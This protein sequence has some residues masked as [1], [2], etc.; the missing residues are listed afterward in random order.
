[1]NLEAI[2]ARRDMLTPWPEID[3]VFGEDEVYQDTIAE[4]TRYV[5][6]SLSN[7]DNFVKVRFVPNTSASNSNVV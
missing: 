3:F 1:M 4:L 5:T 2:L 6:V 7:V